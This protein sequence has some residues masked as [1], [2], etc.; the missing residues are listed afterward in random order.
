MVKKMKNIEMVNAI[1]QLKEFVDKD[2]VVP[3]AISVAISANIKN[4][5]RE[6]EPYHEELTKLQ[7]R[8]ADNQCYQ[9]L[10]GLEVE[11]NLR[12]INSDILE[13]VNISTKDYLAL[14]FMLEDQQ[15]PVSQSE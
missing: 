10:M 2:I 4:M 13:E 3:I 9:E 6:L 15:E 5:I 14:D 12:T 8:K 11:V 7:Q 1:N